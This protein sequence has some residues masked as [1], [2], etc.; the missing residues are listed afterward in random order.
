MENEVDG[1]FIAGPK[2]TISLSATA[3]ILT[4]IKIFF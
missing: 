1:Q 3:T 4:V 2:S